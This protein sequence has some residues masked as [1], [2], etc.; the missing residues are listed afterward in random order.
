MSLPWLMALM[1]LPALPNHFPQL[2][3]GRY[4]L[5]AVVAAVASALLVHFLTRGAAGRPAPSWLAVWLG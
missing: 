1:L 4:A 5:F 3:D 2:L